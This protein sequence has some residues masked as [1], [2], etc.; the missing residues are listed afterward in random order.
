MTWTLS[1]IVTLATGLIGLILL[2][3]VVWLF[4]PEPEV[5][6]VAPAA[7]S[8]D[9]Y[10]FADQARFEDFLSQVNTEESLRGE[11]YM[12]S[13]PLQTGRDEPIDDDGRLFTMNLYRYDV[14]AGIM[15][16]SELP[17]LVWYP[18]R[19]Q[20]GRML[21]V[22]QPSGWA[23][24]D[25][26]IF[27]T[28]TDGSPV[29]HDNTEY[30]AGDQKRVLERRLPKWSDEAKAYAYNALVTTSSTTAPLPNDINS[31]EIF[32]REESGENSS[33]FSD[34]YGPQWF[35]DGQYLIYV[36]E[37][38]IY[39][40]A[41]TPGADHSEVP[42]VR[43]LSVYFP[44]KINNHIDTFGDYI[45]VA[46]PMHHDIRT[47]YVDVYKVSTDVV[48]GPTINRVLSLAME[49]GQYGMWPIF[50]PEGRYLS[51]QTYDP[52]SPMNVNNSMEIYD[53]TTGEAVASYRLNGFY[54]NYA[55][56]TDWVVY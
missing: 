52:L 53:L 21:F 5:E 11:I 7:E 18:D 34:G 30:Q 20:D 16:N 10:P 15:R 33:Y 13:I 42:E 48:E 49:D 50:S 8:Y 40:K 38:G 41:Y 17:F 9:A 45:A 27:L 6:P 56:N 32:V 35:A 25:P 1:R 54:F 55:F 51:V 39:A 29:R 37:D 14:S 43:I 31:W 4:W 23:E 26:S 44:Y 24:Y 3:L 28:D 2:A 47:S 19:L 46:H 22:T 36:K 12:T